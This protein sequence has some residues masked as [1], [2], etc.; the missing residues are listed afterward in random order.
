MLGVQPEDSGVEF[1]LETER[2]FTAYLCFRNLALR[3][4]QIT[5]RW[6]IAIVLPD[7]SDCRNRCYA[8]CDLIFDF[9]CAFVIYVGI[10]LS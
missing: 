10:C 6:A 7:H 1:A 2:S 8:K 3:Y 9:A 5:L 4:P